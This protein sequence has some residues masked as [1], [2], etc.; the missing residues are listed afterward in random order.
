MLSSENTPL[1]SPR[2]DNDRKSFKDTSENL[3][4]RPMLT[5]DGSCKMLMTEPSQVNQ[6]CANTLDKE[7]RTI[8]TERE[9]AA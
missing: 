9:E 5:K 2:N 1:N 8:K 7:L 6:D 3:K 4:L